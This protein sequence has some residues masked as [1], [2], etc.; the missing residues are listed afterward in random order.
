MVSSLAKTL[1]DIRFRDF[2]VC[3]QN[4]VGLPER[5]FSINGSVSYPETKTAIDLALENNNDL[6]I[7]TP[8][9]SSCF[10]SGVSEQA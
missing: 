7:I 3:K 10:T 4:L 9:Y 1:H 2:R 8:E 6:I 5:A